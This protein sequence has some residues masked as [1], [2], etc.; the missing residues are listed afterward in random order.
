MSK[1]IKKINVIY[2]K[3]GRRKIWGE[4]DININTIY[5][6]ER[7]KGKKEIELLIHES[8]HILFP[9]LEEEEIEYKSILLTN[10]LWK[11]GIRKIDNSNNIPL[12]NGRK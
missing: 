7:A 12:Q 4:A 5:I 11:L 6:D 3:L 2:K 10:T 1:L 8:F 9:D